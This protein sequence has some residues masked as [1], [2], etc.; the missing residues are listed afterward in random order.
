MKPG[1]RVPDNDCACIAA[2]HGAGRDAA[3]RPLHR[4][5]VHHLA[6]RTAQRVRGGASDRRARH[7]IRRRAG[8]PRSRRTRSTAAELAQAKLGDGP[9][10]LFVP[11]VHFRLR[12]RRRGVARPARARLE[13]L[14]R[15]PADG[16]AVGNRPATCA[17]WSSRSKSPPPEERN[18]PCIA[19]TP[20]QRYLLRRDRCS[21][22]V[23]AAAPRPS[24]CR[25][26]P[27]SSSRARCPAMRRRRRPAW[28]ATRPNTCYTSRRMRRARTGTRWSSA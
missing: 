19:K 3:D 2:R 27:C 25:P 26:T 23:V 28:P 20:S 11:R 7:R 14:G 1:Y 22:R 18:D 4:A 5:F 17:T 24:R 8:Y 16:R 6:E 15:E 10:P 9:R 21:R 13:P 12:S